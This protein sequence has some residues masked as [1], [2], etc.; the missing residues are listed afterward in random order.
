MLRG[1]KNALTCWGRFVS[2]WTVLVRARDPHTARSGPPPPLLHAHSAHDYVCWSYRADQSGTERQTGGRKI[3]INLILD[4][5][6]WNIYGNNRRLEY[7]FCKTILDWN[8]SNLLAVIKISTVG[9][10]PGLTLSLGGCDTWTHPPFVE[11]DVGLLS[12]CSTVT[13]SSYQVWSDQHNNSNSSSS[14]SVT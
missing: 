14:S 7:S 6:I 1:R 3:G 2:Q 9:K 13:M 5:S 4:W 8:K 12:V 11:K 10:I